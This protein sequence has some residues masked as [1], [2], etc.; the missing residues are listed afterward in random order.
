MPNY[1][2]SFTFHFLM[3]RY[4]FYNQKKGHKMQE[5]A[6]SFVLLKRRLFSAAGAVH[7][8]RTTGRTR[9][10]S[11]VHLG[12]REAAVRWGLRTPALALSGEAAVPQFGASASDRCLFLVLL[13]KIACESLGDSTGGGTPSQQ[14]C[15]HTALPRNC[16]IR[17]LQDW[18]WVRRESRTCAE[19]I[20]ALWTQPGFLGNKTMRPSRPSFGLSSPAGCPGP[21][22]FCSESISRDV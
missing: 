2:V 3:R 15:P 20:T 19:L 10:R 7:L 21:R 8:L 22:D 16:R 1:R 17:P 13:G 12:H 6:F 9:P 4:F 5:N 14:W 11:C 18:G